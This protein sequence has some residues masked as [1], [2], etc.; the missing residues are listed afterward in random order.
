MTLR[1]KLTRNTEA[2]GRNRDAWKLNV[3]D[4]DTVVAD[5]II[6]DH[7]LSRDIPLAVQF[8][9]WLRNVGYTASASDVRAVGAS[10]QIDNVRRVA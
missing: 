1:A 3:F 4:G 6:Y 7:A 8:A 2:M 5:D 9:G 10:F